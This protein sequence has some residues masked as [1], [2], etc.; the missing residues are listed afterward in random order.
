MSLLALF[1][2]P[3]AVSSYPM[4]TE[5]HCDDELASQGIVVTTVLSI[6]TMVFWIFVFKTF[7][8]L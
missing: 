2:S 8:L 3:I 5:M 4:A 6:F 7:N 1:G